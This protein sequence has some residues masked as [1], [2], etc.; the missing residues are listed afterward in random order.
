MQAPRLFALRRVLALGA[1]AGSESGTAKAKDPGKRRPAE[2][3][4]HHDRR[5]DRNPRDQRRNPCGK[6]GFDHCEDGVYE[7]QGARELS[8]FGCV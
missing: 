3:Y 2:Q 8:P 6:A 4:E 7:D 1:P 5:D